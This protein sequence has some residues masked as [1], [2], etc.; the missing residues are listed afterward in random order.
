MMHNFF[1]CVGPYD[2][3]NPENLCFHIV[4]DFFRQLP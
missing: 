4:Y 1:D 2:G 3:R